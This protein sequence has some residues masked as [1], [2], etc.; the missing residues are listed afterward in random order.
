V[1]P[2]GRS[3][4]LERRNLGDRHE[5]GEINLHCSAPQCQYSS[6]P[7]SSPTSRATKLGRALAGSIPPLHSLQSETALCPILVASRHVAPHRLGD[8]RRYVARHGSLLQ[9]TARA[10]LVRSLVAA[11]RLSWS[12]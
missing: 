2:S 8:L 10:S 5:P 1:N 11:D 4:R 7:T 3:R 12:V 6:S 9:S